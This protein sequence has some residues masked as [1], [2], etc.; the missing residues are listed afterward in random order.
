MASNGHFTLVRFKD[1]AQHITGVAELADASTSL[2]Q[3]RAWAAAH[4]EEQFVVF[5]RDLRPVPRAQL[6]QLAKAGAPEP[7]AA[8]RRTRGAATGRMA[9][10]RPSQHS[11]VHT[12]RTQQAR[13]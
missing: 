1:D 3:V 8:A 9:R 4:P 10:T 11:R 13:G 7:P 12:T 5:D 2:Q 6:E